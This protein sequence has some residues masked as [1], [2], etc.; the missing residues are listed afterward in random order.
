MNKTTVQKRAFVIKL[1]EDRALFEKE[2]LRVESDIDRAEVMKLLAVLLV[3]E[4][5]KEE[6]NFLYIKKISE[7]TFG[8]IK[9]ILFKEIAN[10]WLIYSL[11]MLR[12]SREEALQE[13]QDKKRVQ[14][15]LTIVSA[16]L[17]KYQYYIFEEIIDTFLELICTTQD[18]KSNSTLIE[19]IIS[20]ELIEKLLSG[21]SFQELWKGVRAANSSKNMDI[22]RIKSKIN[23]IYE[24]LEEKNLD[25]EKKDSLLKLLAQYESKLEKITHAKLEKF[26]RNLKTIKDAM[27]LSMANLSV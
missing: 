18:S 25:L 26:D 11:E 3:R 24:A 10:E 15:I 12:Y 1:F 21:H 27:A 5:L 4:T 23:E 9:N 13:L 19:E 6:L 17:K 22:K 8:P 16:Y 7:F 20:N 2:I 14:F